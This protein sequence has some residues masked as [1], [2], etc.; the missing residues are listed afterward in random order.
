VPHR[1]QHAA[2]LYVEFG[3]V[4]YR[5]CVRILGDREAAHDAMQEVFLRLLGNLSSFDD[6]EKM[7]PWIVCVARNHCMNLRRDSRNAASLSRELGREES[8]RPDLSRALLAHRLLERFDGQTQRAALSVLASGMSYKEAAVALTLSPS[9][10]A[11]RVNRFLAEARAYLT[12]AEHL[13]ARSLEDGAAKA[14][15]P[16]RLPA[17]DST[18][19]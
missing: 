5:C 3:P 11:R 7:L 1:R 16:A 9:S 8:A 19:A 18:A 14:G 17:A 6:R 12:E 10:V 13:E 4:L 15:E 2:H